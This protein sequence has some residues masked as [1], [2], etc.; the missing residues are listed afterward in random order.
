MFNKDILSGQKSFPKK[1]ALEDNINVIDSLAFQ[2][3][4]IGYMRE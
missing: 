4:L 2:G 3:V 1:V